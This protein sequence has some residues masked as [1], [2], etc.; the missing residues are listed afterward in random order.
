MATRGMALMQQA[1]TRGGGALGSSSGWRRPAL[2]SAR[3]NVALA[4]APRLL[5]DVRGAPARSGAFPAAC[6]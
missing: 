2:L 3:V 6:A 5:R 1:V 4:G